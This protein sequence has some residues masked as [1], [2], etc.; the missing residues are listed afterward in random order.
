MIDRVAR[1]F[2]IK[3]TYLIGDMSGET[4]SGSDFQREEQADEHRCAPGP[5]AT[6]TMAAIQT[7]AR[8][9][10]LQAIAQSP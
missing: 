2:A 1:R 10:R 4:L 5:C 3:P 9:R 7:P 8:T 6:S